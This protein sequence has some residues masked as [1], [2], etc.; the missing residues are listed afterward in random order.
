MAG[1]GNGGRPK[2]V[3]NKISLSRVRA[4]LKDGEQDEFWKTC[5]ALGMGTYV[6]EK[7]DKPLLPNPKYANIVA[8]R[9]EAK[10]AS[11]PYYEEEANALL[12]TIEK[13]KSVIEELRNAKSTN[14]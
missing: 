4:L 5:L 7:G 10:L 6:H 2:G 3:K 14:S 13:L 9:L 11:L 12:E 1:N 8:D